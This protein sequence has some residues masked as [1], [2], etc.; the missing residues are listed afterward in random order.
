MEKITL[1]L[2]LRDTISGATYGIRIITIQH[3]SPRF[4]RKGDIENAA[5]W[6]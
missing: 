1:S 6:F 4:L 3:A 5:F 2:M